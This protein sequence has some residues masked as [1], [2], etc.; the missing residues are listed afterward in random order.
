MD[1]KERLVS[2]IKADLKEYKIEN[3]PLMPSFRDTLSES[4]RAD[5]IAYLVGLK[6]SD[7][8]PGGGR[9]GRG[10]RGQ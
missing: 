5:L 4:E 10:G 7:A 9:G 2:L 3:G 6:S 1:S 8:T